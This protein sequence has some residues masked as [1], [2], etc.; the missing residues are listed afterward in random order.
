MYHPHEASGGCHDLVGGFDTMENAIQAMKENHGEYHAVADILR[1]ETLEH[2][3][4]SY[5]EI[6][7]LI[8]G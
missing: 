3:H 4:Y 5:D 8:K 2:N 7:E 1:V 6:L